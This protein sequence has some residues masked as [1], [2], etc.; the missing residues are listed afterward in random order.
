MAS[1]TADRIPN[2]NGKTAV[3]TGANSGLGYETALKLAE[4]GATV[5]LACR[6]RERGERAVQTIKAAVP[7]A[8]VEFMQL[9]LAS[10][11]SIRAFATQFADSHDRLDLLVNNGGVMGL[12]RTVTEDGPEMQF[13]VN[14]L[15]HFALTGLLLD[16]LAA[17]PDS[18][19]VTVSSRMHAEGEMKWDDLMGE[20]DYDNWDAYRQSKLANLLFAFELQ[21]RLAAGG[22]P[23][24]SIGVHPGRANTNWPA[25]FTGASK[26]LMTAMSRL[27]SQSAEMGA[28][29]PLYAATSPD[30][31]PG[32]Y[33]GPDGD[34]KGYPVETR[35]SDAAYDEA[36]AQR[37]W[38]L[39]EELTGVTYLD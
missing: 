2:L 28:L 23:T 17:A 26:V 11:A 30:A 19:V 16:S 3:V 27:T 7:D 14:H 25:N 37:L 22:A 10:Q 6:N 39:S 24:V 5:V 35:A 32:A 4:H 31:K 21:R 20:Q 36:D 29:S 1:W 13:G 34:T 9:D 15:G 33:Y 38:V 12:P 18:R 8:N